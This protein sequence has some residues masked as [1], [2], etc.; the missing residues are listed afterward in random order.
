MFKTSRAKLHTLAKRGGEEERYSRRKR[1]GMK[2]AKRN[3]RKRN[4]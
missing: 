4:G 2:R 1:N 3:G